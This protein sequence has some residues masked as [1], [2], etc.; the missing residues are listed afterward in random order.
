[1]MN[2][3]GNNGL[4]KRRTNSEFQYWGRNEGGNVGLATLAKMWELKLGSVM[5][6]SEDEGLL[7]AKARAA[8]AK[9]Y[10]CPHAHLTELRYFKNY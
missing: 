2:V 1:M 4:K 5:P 8:Q 6:P 9:I 3:R 10:T 7:Q